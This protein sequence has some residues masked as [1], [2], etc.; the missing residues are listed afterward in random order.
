MHEE[1]FNPPTIVAAGRRQSLVDGADEQNA[2][3]DRRRRTECDA[4]SAQA[5]SSRGG[6]REDSPREELQTKPGEERTV[7]KRRRSASI[8]T[9]GKLSRARGGADRRRQR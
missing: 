9:T 7:G 6:K 5:R 1:R 4:W 3:I 2:E 8:A